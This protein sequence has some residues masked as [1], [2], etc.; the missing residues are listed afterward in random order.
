MNKN[1]DEIV[2]YIF[3]KV[4]KLPSGTKTTTSHLLDQNEKYSSQEMFEIH[5]KLLNKCESENIQLNFDKYKGTNVGLPFN[6]T[7]TKE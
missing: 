6:I 4:K 5:K 3:I 1:I 2:D 7:F